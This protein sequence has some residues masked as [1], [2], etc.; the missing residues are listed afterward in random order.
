M[1]KIIGALLLLA[2]GM[3]NMNAAW[4]ADNLFKDYAYGTD[5]KTYATVKGFY[6]CTKSVGQDALCRNKVDF[7]GRQFT[8]SLLFSDA[9]LTMVSLMTAFS[10]AA[11]SDVRAA[12]NKTF[13]IVRMSDD[14]TV[15][16]IAELFDTPSDQD[17]EAMVN[18]YESLGLSSGKFTY[19]F[20]EGKFDLQGSE[21]LVGVLASQPD[22]IRAADMV[23]ASMPPFNALVIRFSFPKFDSKRIDE[24]QAKPVE[25]F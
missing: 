4:A 20:L 12:L 5:K 22:N 14:K 19:T 10:Q 13:T 11:Y 15:V 3:T 1:R 9:K 6:N 8:L 21:N 7:L 25:A 24:K 23:V 18:R 17:L 2:A 16:D